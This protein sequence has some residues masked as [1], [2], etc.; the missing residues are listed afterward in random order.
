MNLAYEPD[1]WINPN[2]RVA[3]DYERVGR[4]AA[5]LTH[6]CSLWLSYHQGDHA[7]AQYTTPYLLPKQ[8]PHAERI[9]KA[10]KECG[11]WDAPPRESQ[12]AVKVRRLKDGS[13]SVRRRNVDVSDP[14]S[15]A[16]A[17]TVP[18][19]PWPLVYRQWETGSLDRQVEWLVGFI[20][21]VNGDK[22]RQEMLK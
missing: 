16:A 9:N 19:L 7:E 6:L 3:K 20:P 22:V 15:N 18:R 12:S 13:L 10:I 21:Q 2:G 17:Y 14:M 5:W 1:D 4:Q 8:I 11:L